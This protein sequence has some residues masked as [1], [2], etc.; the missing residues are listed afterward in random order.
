VSFPNGQNTI[1]LN[2][3]IPVPGTYWLGVTAPSNLYRNNGGA[4]YPYTLSNLVSITSS[5]ATSTPLD[6]FYYLYNWQV[7]QL[8]C[9]SSQ[10][11]VVVTV[12]SPISPDYSYSNN[13][14][15]YSFTDLTSGNPQSWLWNFGDGITSTLQNPAHTYSSS[16]SYLVQLTVSHGDC[17][18]TTTKIVDVV[19]GISTLNAGNVIF[20][21]PVPAS[22]AVK[23][24]FGQAVDGKLTVDILSIDGQL[25]NSYSFNNVS[26]SIDLDLTKLIDGTYYVKIENQAFLTVKK[27]IVV[28]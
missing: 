21:A 2:F 12:L 26:G 15:T 18:E 8:H 22:E 3:E 28:H 9:E 14:L 23:L 5:N 24:T 10:D 20:L 4:S 11:T 16:G 1:T 25:V 13:L 27:L 7:E 6:Y 19:T 17:N